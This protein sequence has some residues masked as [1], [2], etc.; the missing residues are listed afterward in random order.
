[1]AQVTG[2]TIHS[3]FMTY[4]SFFA[5][6]WRG[7]RFPRDLDE[8][9]SSVEVETLACESVMREELQSTKIR[10]LE[11]DEWP[12]YRELR[13]RA[14]ADSPDAFGSSLAMEQGRPDKEWSERLAWGAASDLDLPLVAM[15]GE[16]AVG[17]AWAKVDASDPSIVNL[18]Q[19]WV[20]PEAR[21]QGLG[22]GL[23]REA[24]AWA[25]ARQAKAVQLAVTVDDSPAMRLYTREGFRPHGPAEPLR[26][27]ASLL[28]LPMVLFLEG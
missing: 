13:L 4:S 21:G 27:G 16:Q 26:Q 3:F 10:R 7:T 28:A 8:V 23:L 11:A 6:P 25:R 1:V 9:V 18:Y 24:I 17:L 19:M 5:G 22:R 15:A 12:L 2:S 20:A 14:L